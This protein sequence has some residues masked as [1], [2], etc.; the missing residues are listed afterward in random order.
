[1]PARVAIG[2]NMKAGIL[3]FS[4]MLLAAASPAAAAAIGAPLAMGNAAS[5][6]S[7][8]A[9]ALELLRNRAVRGLP[10][11]QI[12]LGLIYFTGIGATQD[13]AEAAKWFRLAAEQGF[14]DTTPEIGL[15]IMY[16]DG[17]GV[18]KDA[19]ES[20]KWYLLAAEKGDSSGQLSVGTSYLIGRG[21]PVNYFEAYKW[22]TLCGSKCPDSLATTTIIARKY[23]SPAQRLKADKWVR[24]WKP[25]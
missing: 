23:I 25:R 22:L 24:A 7:S 13:Y 5:D 21:T 16:A 4:L 3:L 8:D 19:A 15:G 17:K 11:A 9:V 20:L 14:P 1:M 12:S 2:D 6:P 18:P 10:D